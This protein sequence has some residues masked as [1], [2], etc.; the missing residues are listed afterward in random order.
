MNHISSATKPATR[1]SSVG[2]VAKK[3]AAGVA[4]AGAALASALTFSAPVHAQS[5]G[6]QAI[7]A[8]S[9]CS[10]AGDLDGAFTG[11]SQMLGYLEC[12]LPEIE[13][14]IDQQYLNMPH[15]SSYRFVPRGM[16]G[17][18]RA[19]CPFDENALQYCLGDQAVFLGEAAVWRL[20]RGIGDAA[21]A[22]V[23]AHELTHHFQNQIGMRSATTANE[24]I[25]YENQADCGA[26]AFMAYARQQGLL[27]GNDDVREL[28]TA[29][30]EVGESEGPRQSHGTVEQRLKS[31]YLA[32]SSSLQ[33][34][35]VACNAFVPETPIIGVS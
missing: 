35:M 31:F 27:G 4:L 5:A 18:T 6:P 28:A 33:S 25:R 32:Y 26:G 29:L 23:V 20:Y 16:R 21:P 9:A 7:S 24:Q 30:V 11:S 10:V 14:W 15:P 13:G 1:A 3:V 19:G 8:K 22:L 2:A 17:S 34:P 12:V